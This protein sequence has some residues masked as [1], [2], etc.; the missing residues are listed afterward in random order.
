MYLLPD[1]TDI[2]YY[3]LY[4]MTWKKTFHKCQDCGKKYRC[5]VDKFAEHEF[6][7]GTPIAKKFLVCPAP[8]RC[9]DCWEKWPL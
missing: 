6:L 5:T 3:G 7:M 8:Y 1:S 4:I 9:A 2:F